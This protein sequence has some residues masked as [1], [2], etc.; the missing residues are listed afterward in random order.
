[1]RPLGGIATT[2]GGLPLLAG[3]LLLAC[4]GRAAAPATAVA[5]AVAPTPTAS[6]PTSPA[7]PQ[8][9]ATPARPAATQPPSAAL[10]LNISEPAP[11]SVVTASRLVVAGCTA[12]GAFVSIGD[13]LVSLDA[14][15]CF[16]TTV[17]LEEGPNSLDVV[18]SDRS[19]RQT[20]VVVTVIYVP[21][22][23]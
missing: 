1:M 16:R 7:A 17:L 14:T 2:K 12:R 20:A 5:T 22:R 3:L 18:A 15:G 21:E 11:E 4:Q 23:A 19:G 8:A 10:F 6:T 9:P 13:D